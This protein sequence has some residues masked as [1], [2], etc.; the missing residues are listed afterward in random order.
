MRHP[1]TTARRLD[2]GGRRLRI[3][4]AAAF[5]LAA[6]AAMPLVS[7]ARTLSPAASARAAGSV[8]QCLLGS[9][10][11]KASVGN[12]NDQTSNE[13]VG[14]KMTITAG[15]PYGLL[16][17]NLNGSSPIHEDSSPAVLRGTET[18]KISAASGNLGVS[19]DASNV[20]QV[21]PGPPEHH[22]DP[23]LLGRTFVYSCTSTSLR[24]TWADDGL[25]STA[26]FRHS[27]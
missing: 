18:M 23:D 13:L 20:T 5:A 24:I 2:R 6:S 16:V 10:V 4:S 12:D 9:W 11:L 3:A 22:V 15:R 14:M 19:T 27:A 7:A 21:S 26:T 8:D 1:H 25:L 17:L